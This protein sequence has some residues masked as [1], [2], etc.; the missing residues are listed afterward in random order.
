MLSLKPRPPRGRLEP[1]RLAYVSC[2]WRLLTAIAIAGT[3]HLWAIRSCDADT[4][5]WPLQCLAIVVRRT[6]TRLRGAAER[7][8]IPKAVRRYRR[9]VGTLA[10]RAPKEQVC[11]ITHSL[12]ARLPLPLPS[13]L[14]PSIFGTGK[15]RM[16]SYGQSALPG[17]Q[18]AVDEHFGRSNAGLLS[19]M[20]ALPWC[21]EVTNQLDCAY[22]TTRYGPHEKFLKI[23][24]PPLTRPKVFL[25][26]SLL[27]YFSYRFFGIRVVCWL[28]VT[29]PGGFVAHRKQTYGGH[30]DP[31]TH[32][33]QCLWAHHP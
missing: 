2:R 28:A 16:T 10:R 7:R 32:T 21:T 29:M 3:T 26:C 8:R 22:V 9:G 27:A 4:T 13:G 18:S 30:H 12:G 1:R 33:T 11:W 24:R 14:L 19:A 20:M 15:R 31:S 17:S 6:N 5:A 23:F 25:S